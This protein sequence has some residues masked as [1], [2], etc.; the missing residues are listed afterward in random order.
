[1]DLINDIV[2]EDTILNDEIKSGYSDMFINLLIDS[3]YSVCTSI[4]ISQHLIANQ[5]RY[6]LAQRR[7]DQEMLDYW[8]F[9]LREH[10]T[11]IKFIKTLLWEKFILTRTCIFINFDSK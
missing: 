2:Q 4:I 1:M 6:R 10:F 11:M 9:I 5:A 3:W 7:P 8:P